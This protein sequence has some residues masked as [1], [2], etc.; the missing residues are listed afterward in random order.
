MFKKYCYYLLLVVFIASCKTTDRHS[1]STYAFASPEDFHAAITGRLNLIKAGLLTQKNIIQICVG[2]GIKDYTHA[3]FFLETQLAYAMWFQ[4]VLGVKT[5]IESKDWEKFHFI[6]RTK[7]YRQS[8]DDSSFVVFSTDEDLDVK[9]QVFS[10]MTVNCQTKNRR[11]DCKSNS[12]TFGYGGPGSV[13]RKFYADDPDKWVSVKN[14]TPASAVLSDGIK[15]Q[16]LLN[17]V[18]KDESLS[19]E[20]KSKFEKQYQKLLFRKKISL[21]ELLRL[22]YFLEQNKLIAQEDGVMEEL[23]NSKELQKEGGQIEYTYKPRISAFHTILHE[24]GHQFGMNH[25]DNPTL[26]SYT[27]DLGGIITIGDDGSLQYKTQNA[28][29]AY[30]K[31]YLYLTP[32]DKAG[33]FKFS[34]LV[35]EFISSK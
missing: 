27:G 35:R 22:S 18:E 25:P 8:L 28:T 11:I 33:V 6:Q 17:A 14:A 1:Q 23:L 12:V 31:S 30:G 15:W 7:C 16:G 4:S 29:M 13:S 2:P 19:L 20:D 34:V 10:P 24:I 3:E 21:E 9:S 5:N 32:D 26:D